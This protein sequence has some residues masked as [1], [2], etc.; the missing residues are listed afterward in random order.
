MQPDCGLDAGLSPVSWKTNLDQLLNMAI[1]VY[2]L[3]VLAVTMAEA[4][5]LLSIWVSS[6]VLRVFSAHFDTSMG[7]LLF[8]NCIPLWLWLKEHVWLF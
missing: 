8:D 5:L 7:I 3:P 2:C 4:H 1:S 6:F